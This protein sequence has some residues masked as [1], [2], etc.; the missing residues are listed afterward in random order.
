ME[1]RSA[2]VNQESMAINPRHGAHLEVAVGHE[3]Q[4][5]AVAAEGIGHGGH[6]GDGALEAGHTE[7]LG[8]LPSRILHRIRVQGYVA[9]KTVPQKPGNQTFLAMFPAE[10]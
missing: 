3:A 1:A 7:V 4:P 2:R 10:S 5:V 6:E 9:K 8:H